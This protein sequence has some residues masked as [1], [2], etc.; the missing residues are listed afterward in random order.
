MINIAVP[1]SVQ[2]NVRDSLG[3]YGPGVGGVFYLF[4]F[5]CR[6]KQR[7]DNLID[8]LGLGKISSG[9]NLKLYP[10]LVHFICDTSLLVGLMFLLFNYFFLFFVLVSYWA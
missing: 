3:A 7:W 9:P 1:T 8:R 5:T 2:L 4:I 10:L 6:R